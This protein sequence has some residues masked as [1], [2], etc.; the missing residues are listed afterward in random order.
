MNALLPPEVELTPF[1]G[2][3]ESLA[4][5]QGGKVAQLE[6]AIRE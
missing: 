6:I 2:C 4:F 3:Y 5:R 1:L